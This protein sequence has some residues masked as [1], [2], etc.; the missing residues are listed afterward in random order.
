MCASLL[1][2]PSSEVLVCSTQRLGGIHEESSAH[3][4]EQL[5]SAEARLQQSQ[6]M[7]E[8]VCFQ[9]VGKVG[10]TPVSCSFK[11]TVNSATQ[12]TE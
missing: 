8:Q 12:C 4:S 3:A 1:L 9:P 10:L 2:F 6:L 5:G 11:R 7:L